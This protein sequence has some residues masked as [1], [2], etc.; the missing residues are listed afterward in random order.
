MNKKQ[1]E[2]YYNIS[3]LNKIMMVNKIPLKYCAI[4]DFNGDYRLKT[5][6]ESST[7]PEKLALLNRA[8][9]AKHDYFLDK[10]KNR[11]ANNEQ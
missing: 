3:E 9:K 7:L 6:D 8:K 10:M 4:K 11:E 2:S 1:A 5:V